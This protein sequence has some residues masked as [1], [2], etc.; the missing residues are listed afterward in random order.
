MKKT[1]PIELITA[2]RAA[3]TL[4]YCELKITW[5]AGRVVHVHLG[6]SISNEELFAK[7]AE[8]FGSLTGPGFYGT[9]RL[10]CTAGR[11]K[12]VLLNPSIKIDLGG[13]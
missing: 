6:E 8:V 10:P 5:E 11:I 7:L 12:G 3:S 9:L 4:E 13:T 2:T 1:D